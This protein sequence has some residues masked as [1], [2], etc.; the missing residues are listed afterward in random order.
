MQQGAIMGLAQSQKRYS[1]EERAGDQHQGT[2][3][4]D[5]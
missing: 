3:G 1:P 5:L 2:T 4:G